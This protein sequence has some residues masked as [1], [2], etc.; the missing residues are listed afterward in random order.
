MEDL[1]M[2]EQD[3]KETEERLRDLKK[4]YHEK[5]TSALRSAI[6]AREEADKLIK[7]EMK[8]L[9]YRQYKDPFTGGYV[10]AG[11]VR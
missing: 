4:E 2:L 11:G 1:S 10:F 8:A 7:E 5:K 6:I 3:I 9:G